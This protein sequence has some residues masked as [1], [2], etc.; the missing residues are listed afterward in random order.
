MCLIKICIIKYYLK[1]ADLEWDTYSHSLSYQLWMQDF[2]EGAPNSQI[3]YDNLFFCQK[4]HEN[5]RI[6]TPSGARVPDAP[7]PWIRQCLLSPP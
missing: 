4:L 1:F 2:P 3:G 6:W 7:P 5:E